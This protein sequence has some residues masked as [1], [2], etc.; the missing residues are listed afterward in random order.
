MDRLLCPRGQRFDFNRFGAPSVGPPEP[1][2]ASRWRTHRRRRALHRRGFAPDD[3]RQH[4]NHG[5]QWAQTDHLC[6]QQPAATWSTGRGSQSGLGLQRPRPLELSHPARRPGMPGMV[7][8]QGHHPWRVGRRPGQS[9]NGKSACY[10]EIVTAGRAIRRGSAA[11]HQRLD[12]VYTNE[13][14]TIVMLDTWVTGSAA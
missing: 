1:R 8:G 5:T 3:R 13:R 9:V 14:R 6:A 11:A 12:T 10:I 7:H 2:W 4:G